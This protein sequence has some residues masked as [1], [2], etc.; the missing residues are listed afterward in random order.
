MTPAMLNLQWEKMSL[1]PAGYFTRDIP[2]QA[3]V[4]YPTGWSAATSLDVASRAGSRISYRPVPYETLVDS[5][6]FAGRYYRREELGNNMNLNIFADEPGDLA[7]TPEQIA[8]HRRL[9]EQE[10]RLYGTQHFSHYEFLLALTDELGGIGLEHLR[11]SENSE[12]R[13]YFTG[14]NNGSASRDLLAHESNHSWDGKYRRGADL[15]T[16]TYN[17]PMRDSLLWVYEGQDQFWGYVLAARSGLMPTADV[18][19]ELARTAALLRHA[20]GPRLAAFDR[21]HQRSHRP[22]AAAA[23][24]GQLDAQRGLLFRRHADL[25]RGRCE[26]APAERRPALDERFRARLLRNQS[27]RPGAGDLHVRRRRAHAQRARALRLGRLAARAG[28][29]YRPGA[30]RLDRGG[31]LPAR[32]SRHADPLS[33]LARA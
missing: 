24:L 10:L 28:L 30:A 5:P 7:A 29:S 33:H 3:N 23:A 15:W 21:H 8:A 12:G 4:T 19:G 31:R 17:V 13:D 18:L 32:L 11:S 6:V 27:G 22:V 2:I 16:P 25:A 26:I 20:A 14:W 9:A 1:Y